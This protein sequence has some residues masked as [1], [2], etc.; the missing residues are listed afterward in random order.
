[1][2]EVWKDVNGYEGKYKISNLG[3]LKN[4]RGE[5]INGSN[6]HGYIRVMLFGDKK[7]KTISIHRLVAIHFIENDNNKPY[8]NHIDGNK[9]NNRVDNLEWC[10]QA[11]NIQHSIENG[12]KTDCGENSKKHKLTKEDVNFIRT[13]YIPRDKI[14]SAKELAKKFNIS[15]REIYRVIKGEVFQS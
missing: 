1:M 6:I 14:Y 10:T 3:R 2:V 4:K 15:R 12:L 11:E 5:F 8:V 13:R 7:V 9:Q